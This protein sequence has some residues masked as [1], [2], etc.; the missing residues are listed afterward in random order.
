MEN[1]FEKYFRNIDSG[2][3]GK[4]LDVCDGRALVVYD[5]DKNHKEPRAEIISYNDSKFEKSTQPFVK[6]YTEK[7]FKGDNIINDL[8]GTVPNGT[9]RNVEK[10]KGNGISLCQYASGNQSYLTACSTLIPYNGEILTEILNFN[11]EK[12]KR[13]Q[14]RQTLDNFSNLLTTDI[15]TT[16]IATTDIATNNIAR[17]DIARNDLQIN[18]ISNLP[19]TDQATNNSPANYPPIYNLPSQPLRN[20]VRNQATR[21]ELPSDAFLHDILR[22]DTS[23]I[24]RTIDTIQL[25]RNYNNRPTLTTYNKITAQMV[26]MFFNNF[27]VHRNNERI[28]IK[29]NTLFTIVKSVLTVNILGGRTYKISRENCPRVYKN[30]INSISGNYS[31]IT[32]DELFE[33]FFNQIAGTTSTTLFNV[34]NVYINVE[35]T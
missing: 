34:Y 22:N 35:Q 15:A 28:S 32:C 7:L 2:E 1:Q 30:I 4:I 24:N 17:N 16:D 10:P 6:D 3:T 8:T 5:R 29:P 14:N 12:K 27:F 21:N 20:D 13:Q 31:V 18:D 11:L 25:Y 26:T 19:T 33:I 23:N 9:I